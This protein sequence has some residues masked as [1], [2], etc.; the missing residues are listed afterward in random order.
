MW[1]D[2]RLLA[3]VRSNMHPL[4]PSDAALIRSH[5]CR[6]ETC[7]SQLVTMGV[8]RLHV[9]TKAGFSLKVHDSLLALACTLVSCN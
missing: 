1:G 4:D 2:V 6:I 9:P 3:Q 5:H 7:H 8:Q